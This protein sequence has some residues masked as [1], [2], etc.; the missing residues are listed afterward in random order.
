MNRST[1]RRCEACGTSLVDSDT[2]PSALTLCGGPLDDVDTQVSALWFDEMGRATTAPRAAGDGRSRLPDITVRE[3]RF[4]PLAAVA[5]EPTP[6]AASVAGAAAGP[7][8]PRPAVPPPLPAAPESALPPLP[9]T[10]LPTERAARAAIKVAQRAAVRRA[11]QASASPQQTVS[12]VLV[13]DGDA[14]ARNQ[15]DELLGD[16]GFRVRPVATLAQAAL[17]AGFHPFAAVFVAVPPGAIDG[18][19]HD[20]FERVREACRHAGV[21]PAV[22]VLLAVQWSPVDR[23]R[24][25]LAGCEATLV[26]PVNRRDLARVL[27]TNGVV[28]PRDPRR[29]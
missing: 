17:L 15:L 12:D 1:A 5:P 28:L 19:V 14:T 21:A 23:V 27:D 25:E 9:A 18:A 6:Q 22:R 13:M 4:T 26:R 2:V 24:A 29:A 7:A 11:R 16:L 20:L 10:P 8:D 3:I